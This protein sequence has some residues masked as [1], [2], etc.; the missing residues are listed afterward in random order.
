MFKPESNAN[1]AHENEEM[2]KMDQF[3]V[4][5]HLAFVSISVDK[6]HSAIP[7]FTSVL[8]KLY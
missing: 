8:R 5:S 7:S 3:S 1:D 4:V 2:T 6:I